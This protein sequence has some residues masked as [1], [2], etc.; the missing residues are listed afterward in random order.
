[1]PKGPENGARGVKFV[2][3]CRV[4]VARGELSRP[5]LGPGKARGS[6]LCPGAAESWK[7]CEIGHGS[8]GG[9]REGVG[10]RIENRL[11]KGRFGGPEML[12]FYWFLKEIRVSVRYRKSID[13]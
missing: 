8:D 4:R 2:A 3:R 12:I 1:M 10:I 7:M 11:K 13:F 9:R 6:R 5:S